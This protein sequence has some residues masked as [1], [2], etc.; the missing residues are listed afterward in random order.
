[1]ANAF[2][3]ASIIAFG[4]S[5]VMALNGY[6]VWSLVAFQLVQ[7]LVNSILVIYQSKWFPGFQFDVSRFKGLFS[8]GGYILITQ[9]ALNGYNEIQSL[10]IGRVFSPSTLGYYTQARNLQQAPAN[11]VNTVVPQV[12]YPLFSKL[13]RDKLALGSIS[14]IIMSSVAYI[15]V[16][17]MFV[18]MI[19]SVPLFDI[20]YG[21]KWLVC[22]P[23]F[24]ILCFS[25]ITTCLSD[26]NYYI[27]ASQGLGKQLLYRSL[28]N[29][30]LG[31]ILVLLSAHWGIYGIL[32]SVVLLSYNKFLVNCYLV[33]K[34]IGLSIF[35][36]IKYIMPMI[37]ISLCMYGVIVWMNELWEV[38]YQILFL[39][40][41]LYVVGYYLITR[42]I[43]LR[44]YIW[45][46]SY[47]NQLVK[48]YIQ[49][50]KRKKTL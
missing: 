23:Y 5:V 48:P 33:R 35:N 30:G 42:L 3:I 50:I 6:G 37:L 26:I 44:A 38:S 25:G 20:L 4:V 2:I 1:M 17:L 19:L 45:I 10:V 27:I 31:L 43:R 36:Q 49:Q 18:L 39:E 21:S 8:F 41:I 40:A 7:S 16:P 12:A 15:T 29:N 14:N 34:S 28:Y 13:Q 47:F 9:L 11:I 46:S 24:A 32:L 22:A